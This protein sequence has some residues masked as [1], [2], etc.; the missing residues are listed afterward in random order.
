MR[1]SRK[2]L[3]LETLEELASEK[4]TVE[5]LVVLADAYGEKQQYK[6]AVELYKRAINSSVADDGEIR[7]KLAFA[8][9][10]QKEYSQAKVELEAI[11]KIR[12][13][14]LRP[15]EQLYLART[16]DSLG[17]VKT[18]TPHFEQVA[19]NYPSVESDYY[20]CQFLKKTGRESEIPHHV[21]ETKKKYQEMAKRFRG[22]SSEWMK[23]VER[24]FR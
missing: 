16:L 18:A 1:K 17:D 21:K 11:S 8:L 4:P 19:G 7:K 14:R 9:F 5:N 15:D 10:E 13:G 20:Y 23:R 12:Q 6:K 24:E 3:S 22:E 2:K